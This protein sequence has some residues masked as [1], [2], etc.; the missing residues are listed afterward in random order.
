MGVRKRMS[1]REGSQEEGQ[2]GKTGNT[3][4]DSKRVIKAGEGIRQ[5]RRGMR[6][7]RREGG[8]ITRGMGKEGKGRR[9]PEMKQGG[10]LRRANRERKETRK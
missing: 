8:K 10:A 9:A 1:N 2:E 5:S 3:E 7:E 4:R 6:R